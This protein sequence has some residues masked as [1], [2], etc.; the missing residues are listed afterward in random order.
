MDRHQVD[1][2]ARVLRNA[3]SKAE[4]RG[5]SSITRRR[6]L[7]SETEPHMGGADGRAR[8]CKACYNPNTPQDVSGMGSAVFLLRRRP[9]GVIFRG[10]CLQMQTRP[11]TR[12]HS[13]SH[14]RSL[15][16]SVA[17]AR[18]PPSLLPSVLFLF[19][20]A[21]SARAQPQRARMPHTTTHTQ[22]APTRSTTRLG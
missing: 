9:G 18:S 5:W 16:H 3:K 17:H 21:A 20:S 19:L 14:F 7:K 1:P 13:H 22:S 12:L 10:R 6:R 15:S 8:L 11:S 4:M 2:H